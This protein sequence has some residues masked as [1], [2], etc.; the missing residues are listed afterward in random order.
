MNNRNR[1]LQLFQQNTAGKTT[2]E[3]PRLEP[4]K[5]QIVG[6]QYPRMDKYKWQGRV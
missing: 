5:V 2:V 4:S 3:A 1:L 6:Y